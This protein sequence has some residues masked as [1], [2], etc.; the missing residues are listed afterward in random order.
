ARLETV[1]VNDGRS[2]DTLERL[3]GEFGLRL[4]PRGYWQQLKC[5]PARGVYWSPDC[6]R[7]C[8]LD[9][10]N[11][12]KADA[13]NAGINLASAPYVSVIDGDTDIDDGAMLAIMHAILP[14]V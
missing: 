5:K 3:I 2:D 7:L 9:K 11:G 4:T 6:A 10:V 13:V 1:V 14:D 12:R 8:V